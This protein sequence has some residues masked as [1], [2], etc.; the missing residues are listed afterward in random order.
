MKYLATAFSV[1]LMAFGF[2]GF[3]VASVQAGEGE[4]LATTPWCHDLEPADRG[5]VECRYSENEAEPTE[6]AE[7][8]ANGEGGESPVGESGGEG[9]Q[10]AASTA[11]E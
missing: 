9:D 10:A 11:A 8:F 5:R 3:T 2:V 6:P 7:Q 4:F 1:A